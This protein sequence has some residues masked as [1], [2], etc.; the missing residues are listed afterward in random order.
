M[1]MMILSRRWCSRNLLSATPLLIN[2]YSHSRNVIISVVF[3]D[4]ISNVDVSRGVADISVHA[5]V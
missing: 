3:E 5:R 1:K 2:V 4:L